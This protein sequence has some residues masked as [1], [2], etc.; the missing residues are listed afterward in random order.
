MFYEHQTSKEQQEYIK[1]LQIIGSL[2]NLFSQSDVPYL[3]Y[4]VAEKVFCKAFDAKDLSRGDVA[5]DAYKN[6]VGIGLKTFLANNNRTFQKVAEF[7][8]DKALYEDKTP[9]QLVEKISELRNKRIEFTQ[10][11]Y[12]I[13]NSLYHCVVRESGCFKVYEE[14]MDIVDI[15]NIE[16]VKKKK[17]SISFHDTHHEYIF[18]ISK[19]TL[20]KRFISNSFQ[21][22][23]DVKILENPF[24]ELQN[25]F[26]KQEDSDGIYIVDTIFLPL[27][28]K[29][30]KVSLR[31]GLNQWN[32]AG[33]ERDVD[34]VYIPIPSKVH[35]IKPDFFPDRDH[36]FELILPDDNVLQAK[37]CQDNS[38]ALM[39]YSNK[40]LGK[41]I[42]RDVLQ[43][44]EGKLL[45]YEMLQELGI[46]S[47]KIDKYSDNSYKINFAQIDSYENFILGYSQI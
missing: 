45:T 43:L 13:E 3:Y 35:H 11:L 47:V 41:W 20:L 7:N 28:S 37:V 5:L 1:K 19:S 8:K 12:G 36:S 30:K 33:R 44:P 16:D 40:E 14:S 42:L 26:S 25:C 10:N 18:N 46:D 38:K 34:E 6:G 4:R 23:F 15:C 22:E 17:N 9:K 29:G 2:S 31:S 32:A 27:Y 21:V 24:E 39:S